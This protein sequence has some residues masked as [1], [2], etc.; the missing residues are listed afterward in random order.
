M[1]ISV[2]HSELV[3]NVSLLALGDVCG[4]RVGGRRRVKEQRGGWKKVGVSLAMLKFLVV[5]LFV[6]QPYPDIS[7]ILSDC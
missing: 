7:T 1:C 5:C 6:S 4:G 3:D 2:L